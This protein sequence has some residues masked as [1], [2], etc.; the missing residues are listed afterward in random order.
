MLL[1]SQRCSCNYL[2]ELS[3]GPKVTEKR[4]A[5]LRIGQET[6]FQPVCWNTEENSLHLNEAKLKKKKTQFWSRKWGGGCGGGN[7]LEGFI[8]SASGL[9]PGLSLGRGGRGHHNYTSQL[10]WTSSSVVKLHKALISVNMEQEF[11]TRPGHIKHTKLQTVWAQMRIWTLGWWLSL[12]SPWPSKMTEFS[13]TAHS[14]LGSA[15][16]RTLRV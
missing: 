9:I 7:G 6:V 14:A 1:D 4:F 2:E 8:E 10:I 5:D 16:G 11:H 15:Q 3:A 12:V 13:C